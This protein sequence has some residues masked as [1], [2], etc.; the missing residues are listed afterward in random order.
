MLAGM[1]QPLKS[2]FKTPLVCTLSGEDIFLE[3]L[4][5]PHYS[6]ARALLKQQARHIDRFVALNNYFADF[7]ADY[8]EVAREK[9]EVIPH[10]L[11]QE[12]HALRSRPRTANQSNELVIGYF[13]RVAAEKGLHILAEAFCLLAERTD[14][15][16]LRLKAAGYMSSADEAYFQQIVARLCE[17]GHTERFEYVGELDRPGKIAFLQSLDV[18]SVPTVY[19]E[20]KGI[21]VLEAMANGVP[22]VLPRHGMF[23]ELIERT[24]AGLLC[25]PLDPR[26]LADR[27]AELILDPERAA[28]CGRRGYA[29]IQAEHT[30][31]LMASRHLDLYHKLLGSTAESPAIDSAVLSPAATS[32]VASSI[33]DP[34]TP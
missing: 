23:P 24:G 16:P 4:E 27:L 25:E 20:S 7:M 14:L 21:S 31:E 13:A 30:A 3:Q 18:M 22:L 17:A 8:L 26:S 12:G 2:R 9:I 11:K 34:S 19:H 33:V 1:A 15:P 10:G 5:E 29:A 6:Q 32:P 28:E